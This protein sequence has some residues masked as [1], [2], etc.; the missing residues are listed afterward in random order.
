MNLLYEH[1]L[2]VY[3]L[4]ELVLRILPIELS[5]F[6]FVQHFLIHG[7]R[8]EYNTVPSFVQLAQKYTTGIYEFAFFVLQFVVGLAK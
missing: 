7:M 6:D 5:I 1:Q 8:L 3:V 2:P 4:W